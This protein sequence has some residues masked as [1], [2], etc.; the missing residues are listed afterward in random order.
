[1][2][3]KFSTIKEKKQKK[4]AKMPT[5]LKGNYDLIT[6]TFHNH[7]SRTIRNSIND[8]DGSHR[9]NHAKKL[10]EAMAKRREKIEDMDL[11]YPFFR[12]V[13]NNLTVTPNGL[14]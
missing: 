7:D 13:V 11:A 4:I 8:T 12:D 14:L 10:L 9:M 2:A 3:V 5:E 6:K 1:M